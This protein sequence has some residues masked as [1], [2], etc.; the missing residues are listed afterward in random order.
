MAWL[1]GVLIPEIN[2]LRTRLFEFEE[3]RVEGEK[4]NEIAAVSTTTYI[5]VVFWFNH[6]L[7]ILS[8]SQ[9]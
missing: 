8:F 9:G 4:K 7:S 6:R 2:V 5:F 1:G 3:A